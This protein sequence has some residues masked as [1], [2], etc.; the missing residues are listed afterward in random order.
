[1]SIDDIGYFIIKVPFQFF[2]IS[3][4]IAGLTISFW[5]LFIFTGFV[6]I[7]GVLFSILRR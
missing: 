2:N 3:F 5:D 7:L 1:M 4:N 6:T